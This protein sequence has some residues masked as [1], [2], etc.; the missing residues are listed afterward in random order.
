MV[1]AISFYAT[2][3]AFEKFCLLTHSI[4]VKK[5]ETGANPSSPNVPETDGHVVFRTRNAGFEESLPLTGLRDLRLG[6]PARGYDAARSQSPESTRSVGYK[7]NDS[8]SSLSSCVS[9]PSEPHSRAS[10]ISM[11]GDDR[12]LLSG[13]PE[14]AVDEPKLA[15]VCE[16]ISAPG[17]TRATCGGYDYKPTQHRATINKYGPSQNKGVG[18]DR[19]GETLGLGLLP[20]TPSPIKSTTPTRYVVTSLLISTDSSLL[21]YTSP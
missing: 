6:H 15:P 8:Y 21:P 4:I 20:N 9:S 2:G 13:A 1:T 18:D 7:V 16:A 14:K 11:P 12:F 17:R 5:Q 10:S 3:A 19:L